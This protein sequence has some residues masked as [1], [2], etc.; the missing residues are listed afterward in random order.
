MRRDSQTGAS[1]ILAL[2][3]VA[4]LAVLAS[5]LVAVIANAQHNAMHE[6]T[7]AQSFNVTEAAL[8]AAMSNVALNWPTSTPVPFPTTSFQDQ[9]KPQ[10]GAPPE[11]PATPGSVVP[12]VTVA[13]FDNVDTNGD[14]VIDANDSQIDANGDDKMYIVTQA[15]VL[16]SSSRVRALVQRSSFEPQ[17]P[18][19]DALW[20]GGDVLVSGGG[21][22]VMPKVTV[23]NASPIA[24][25]GVSVDVL[26]NVVYYDQGLIDT[27][28]IDV[29]FTGTV[30]SPAP[31]GHNQPK[32]L[33][34]TFPQSAREAIINYAKLVGRYF[35]VNNA[36]KGMTPLQTAQASSKSAYGGPGIAGLT[37][38]DQSFGSCDIR[39]PVNDETSPGILVLLGG[40]SLD[41]G[42]NADFYGLLYVQDG[43]IT[44][45]H[46]TPTVHG[47]VYG[48]GNITFAG[49]CNLSFDYLALSAFASRTLDYTVTIVPN[50]W[51][52]LQ[53]R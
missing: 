41:I 18:S 50:T 47:A 37:V 6:R 34:E 48:T 4:T 36:T 19:T 43:T 16:G 7:R 52:E 10:S 39:D 14:G 38:I 15:R 32:T 24:V 35:D 13:Y 31:A 9:F 3:M 17:I 30:A 53:P 29:Q 49:T 33:E 1:L 27:S 40:I 28:K 21:L 2:G 45:S 5:T 46:G 11:Y 42:G 51:R 26:G 20:C 44:F 12:D 25:G 22:G 8:D 23:G